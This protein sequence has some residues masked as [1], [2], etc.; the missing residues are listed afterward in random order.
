MN[1]VVNFLVQYYHEIQALAGIILFSA[2]ARYSYGIV[3]NL[4]E[5][6]EYALARFFLKRKTSRSFWI[7]SVSALILS[8]GMILKNIG[9]VTGN[10]AYLPVALLSTILMLLGLT[11][12]TLNIYLITKP[13]DKDEEKE[14][15]EEDSEESEEE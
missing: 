15:K 13:T 1:E 3:K 4:E 10:K 14:G 2:T 8:F 7:V 9:I 11:Y 12:F 6:Q 5:K